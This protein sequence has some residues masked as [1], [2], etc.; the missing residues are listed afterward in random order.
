MTMASSPRCYFQRMAA[1]RSRM[2]S[3]ETSEGPVLLTTLAAV[4]V[5]TWTNWGLE[6]D[7]LA[8]QI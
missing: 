3:A 2:G 5:H 4:R 1:G 6:H 8:G 7:I